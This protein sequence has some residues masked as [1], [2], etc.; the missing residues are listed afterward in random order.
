MP[1]AAAAF[2]LPAYRVAVVQDE[3][4]TLH[5]PTLDVVGALGDRERW[6]CQ[7][8]NER[9]F[10]SLLAAQGEFDCIALGP[11]V[12][13]RNPRIW[14]SI[15]AVTVGL[16]VLH[17]LRLPEEPGQKPPPLGLSVAELEREGASYPVRVATQ[18][19]PEL[20]VLLNWPEAIDPQALVARTACA[21]KPAPET[22]WRPV[23]ELEDGR[24]VLVRS[25]VTHDPRIV[26][27]SLLLE[28]G[29][30]SHRDLL[31]NMLVFC[32][33]GTPTT[34][35]L[36]DDGARWARTLAR[37]L[38]LRGVNAV[39][40]DS[41]ASDL[42]F[43]RWPLRTASDV[44]VPRGLPGIPG[45][46]GWLARG[47]RLT[48]VDADTGELHVLYKA[49]DAHWV[50]RRWSAWAQTGAAEARLTSVMSAR[51]YHRTLAALR[52]PLG[53]E[54]ERFGLSDPA[55]YVDEVCALVASR[56][57]PHDNLEETISATAALLELGQLVPGS[58]ELATAERVEAWL[59]AVAMS[60]GPEDQLEI[61]HVLRDRSLLEVALPDLR[62]PLSASSVSR[63]R[64]AALASDALELDL[65]LDD[66][67]RE[68]VLAE[69]ATSV[70]RAAEYLSSLAAVRA[71][72]GPSSSAFGCA[73][74]LLADAAVDGLLRHGMLGPEVPRAS[75]TSEEVCA[76]ALALVTYLGL[77]DVPTSELVR[78]ET[79]PP[80]PFV[81]DALREGLQV[82]VASS[83]VRAEN[84]RL[85][86]ELGESRRRLELARG[87]LG[88]AVVVVALVAAA[89]AAWLGAEVAP[90][91]AFA[92]APPFVAPLTVGPLVIAL[93]GI[94]LAHS[95][96]CPPWLVTLGT[97]VGG[98]VA[99]VRAFALGVL[100][101]AT[102]EDEERV[103]G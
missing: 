7:L 2:E 47:G 68:L 72:Q 16:L 25:L 89:A 18:R 54:L 55:A 99:G 56:L 59:R 30:E 44:I 87:L 8:F 23:L 61:A 57:G 46:E 85:T 80:A 94:P 76:E 98:G 78:S 28:S 97:T 58:I 51:A 102:A 34:V 43:A 86:G 41:K 3:S 42:D 11:N 29:T 81:E 14:A 21:L 52:A 38:R 13:Y 67:H 48:A 90:S 92:F 73:D 50:A 39:E 36:T 63:V 95:R 65:P 33:A 103:G 69:V 62:R 83:R 77:D 31:R 15:E 26:V 64:R 12:V 1:A 82:R 101:R 74:G 17:Q 100:G 60:A 9:T 70:L 84:A 6:R 4:E 66:E 37:K 35:A 88:I 19:D 93:L 79:A 49:P 24:P 96:L 22:A 71:A 75:R 10:D 53:D 40:G 20:E 91:G 5:N 45:Q 32:A 27:C